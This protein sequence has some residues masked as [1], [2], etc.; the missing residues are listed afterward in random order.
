MKQ[1]GFTLIELLVVISIIGLLSSIVLASLNTAREKARDAKRQEDLHSIQVALELYYITHGAYPPFRPSSS[2][3][4]YRTDWATSK[5]TEPNWLSTDQDFLN[6]IKPQRDPT[7]TIVEGYGDTP[8]WSAL[9]YTYGVSS[10]RQKYDLITNL[11]NKSNPER[12]E[13]KLWHSEAVWPTDTGCY[14]TASPGTVPDRAKQ[15]WSPK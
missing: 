4:G 10:D 2:C 7:N 12:C 14:S 11:E 1:R 5:C 15:I 9:T 6:F 3:G 8:W 13:L